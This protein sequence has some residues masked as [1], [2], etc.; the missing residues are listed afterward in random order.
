MSSAA[1]L[2][3]A[4]TVDDMTIAYGSFVVQKDLNFVVKRSDIF[5]V[6]G[7]SG[8]G[9]SSIMNSLIGLV[10]PAKGQ[11]LYGDESFWEVPPEQ[12]ATP[13]MTR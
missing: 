11:V 1:P 13:Q 2:D 10:R 8:C 7:G 12:K 6:M 9:K 3:A 5:I 4:I